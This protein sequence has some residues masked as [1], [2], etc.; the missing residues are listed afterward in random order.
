MCR[1]RRLTN[2]MRKLPPKTNSQITAMA[3]SIGHSSS[4]YS[5]LWVIPNGKVK[6]AETM[7]ACQPQKWMLLS[8]S[9]H[10]RALQSRW[11]E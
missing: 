8:V 2:V 11:V 6:A 10:I 7:I 1:S 3:M 4:A 9:L 5:L